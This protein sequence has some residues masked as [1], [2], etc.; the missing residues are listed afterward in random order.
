MLDLNRDLLKTVTSRRAAYRVQARMGQIELRLPTR[1][2]E[3][4]VAEFC[5][6]LNPRV[7]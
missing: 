5:R 1:R 4:S 6:F 2:D 3:A 7:I